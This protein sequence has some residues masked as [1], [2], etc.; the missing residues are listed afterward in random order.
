MIGSG[1]LNES[2]F[3]KPY[4]RCS[5]S[6]PDEPIEPD[7]A[8]HKEKEQRKNVQSYISAC[9]HFGHIPISYVSKHIND[10]HFAMK[11]HPLGAEGTRALC[12]AL[13]VGTTVNKLLNI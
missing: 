8:D 11:C 3:T 9:R 4:Q 7:K 13:V 6:I 5:F 10:P 2:H 12:I 1:R